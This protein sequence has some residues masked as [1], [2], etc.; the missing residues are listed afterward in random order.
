[1]SVSL[2]TAGEE[3]DVIYL[4]MVILFCACV[5]AMMFAGGDW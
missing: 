2:Q 3:G 5:I 1:M 4:A